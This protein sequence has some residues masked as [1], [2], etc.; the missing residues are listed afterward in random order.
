[1]RMPKVGCRIVIIN[2]EAG[3]IDH[4]WK[5]FKVTS[6]I[7]DIIVIEGDWFVMSHQWIYETELV[8]ALL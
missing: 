4:L 8:K 2:A 6:F 3:L 5:S 7:N 1:M